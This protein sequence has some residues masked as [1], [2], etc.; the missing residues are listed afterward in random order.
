MWKAGIQVEGELEGA[1]E[2][3]VKRLMM[4]E[5]GEEMKLRALCLIGTLKVYVFAGAIDSSRGRHRLDGSFRSRLLLGKIQ[6]PS[7]L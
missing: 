4:D 7:A 2:R 1:V 6:Y 3:A 5:E